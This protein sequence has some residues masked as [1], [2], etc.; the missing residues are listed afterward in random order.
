MCACSIHSIYNS[1]GI[2]NELA[3]LVCNESEVQHWIRS[4]LCDG[5]SMIGT[6]PLFGQNMLLVL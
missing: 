6:V 3:V 5:I 4:G 1:G 2:T